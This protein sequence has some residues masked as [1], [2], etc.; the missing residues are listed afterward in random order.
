M[1]LT[2]FLLVLV[3]V[4]F[5]GCASGP[6]VSERETVTEKSV[7]EEVKKEPVKIVTTVYYPIKVESYFGD[8]V[9]DEYSVFTYDEDG[10]FLLKE[11]LFNGDDSLQQSIVSEYSGS[12]SCIRSTY[13]A[14]GTL[15]SYESMLF[16]SDGNIT[17]IEKF[18]N[19]NIIQSKSIYEY[20]DGM[21]SLWM[22]YNE[23]ESLLSTT[24]YTYSDLDLLKIE[25]L[26][27]GG[28]LEDYFEL[29]YN[30][31]GLLAENKH[32]DADNKIQDSRTFE[33]IDGFLV[34]EMINRKNGSVL[35]KIMHKNDQF[36]NHV[37]SV[38]MD[39]GDNVKERLITSYDSR[40]EINY[41]K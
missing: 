31:D 16:D 40:E 26:S 19:K 28:D 3:V 14:A 38:F 37:E 23:S 11:E 17:K 4:F 34:M 20:V 33:Y 2:S 6:Q 41:E 8:G 22:V 7:T 5:F 27:P 30:I 25:S 10:I 1:K 24:I 12:V 21:K 9:K 36:G 13:D 18:D 32:Y 15:L 35:R 39:A 29:N